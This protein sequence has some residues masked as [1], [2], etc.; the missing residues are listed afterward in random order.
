MNSLSQIFVYILMLLCG[1]NI[2]IPIFKQNK[3]LFWSPLTFIS[4]VYLYYVVV[5]VLSG[6]TEYYGF[7]AA[8]ATDYAILGG[9]VSYIFVL[10]GFRSPCRS[11]NFRTYNQV[12]DPNKGLVKIAIFLFVIG[13]LGYGIFRGFSLSIFASSKDNEWEKAGDFE[14]Y[15]SNLISLGC[16]ASCLLLANNNKKLLL[17]GILVVTLILDIIAGSRYRMVILMIAFFTVW[18]L[19][20]KVKKVNYYLLVPLAISA[21]LFFA[22]MD[23]ARNYG[24]GLNRSAVENFDISSS[25]GAGENSSVFSFSGYVMSEYSERDKVYL[26]PLWCAITLP[27]P[28]AIFPW[29]PNADYVKRISTSNFG[30]AAFTYYAE[31]YMSFGWLGLMLYAFLFGYVS[32]RVWM[33]YINNQQNVNAVLF[34]ALYN[35][36]TYVVVSR[37]YMAQMVM[38]AAYFVFIP[39]WIPMLMKK[40][41]PGLINNLQ[42]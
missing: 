5:P 38:T 27:I 10:I 33:N 9:L 39:F 42:K 31:A 40:Y 36:I 23:S 6:E 28:R 3:A 35:G 29:K 22:M 14:F 21:Y 7:L 18:H 37:G 4:A 13:F 30:G 17:A 34:L 1:Y 24:S 41:F 12:F 32:K 8:D 26:E 20:P 2:I 16:A 25:K 19:Y 11:T 15:F